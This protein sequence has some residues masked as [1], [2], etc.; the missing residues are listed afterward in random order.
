MSDL[1]P[2]PFPHLLVRMMRELDERESIFDLPRSKFFRGSEGDGGGGHDLSV[3]LHGQAAATPLGPSAGPHSQMAQN[4]VL[5]YL[6]GSR[7]MELKTVQVLDQLEIGRPCID[8]AT[9]CYNIEWSQEL[10]IAE[11][12]EE[13]VKA[14]MLID[15]LVASGRLDL[16]PG[17][18]PV[19]YDM[20]VGYD[21]AGIQSQPVRAFIEGMKDATAIVERLRTQIPAEFAQFR[22]LDF[23]TKLSNSLTLS[24]FHGCPPDEI[25][26][27]IDFL[28]R[29]LGLDC[30]IKL[31][32]TLLGPRR[33]KELLID[34]LGY[35]EAVTPDEAFEKD[36][37]WEQMLGFV[38]RLG[39]TAT[40]L[41]LGLGVKFT[42]TLIV[43]NHRDFFPSSEKQM[44]LSGQPLHVL[45][46]NLV[47]D[48]RR[49][50][51]D[52]VPVSFSAGI[53]RANFPDAVASGLVP[54][55]VCS[56]LLRPGGYGRQKSYFQSL[57]KRMD[58]V[59]ANDIE[60]FILRAYGATRV[61]LE[62]AGGDWNP[63]IES[64]IENGQD[65]RPIV[66]E[67][68]LGRWLGAAK[69]INT[70]L[71]T[72]QATADERYRRQQTNR[73]PK[74]IGSMLELFNCI[75]CDK[76]I[77]V[78]P[79]DANF[80]LAIDEVEVPLIKVFKRGGEWVSEANGTLVLD[81]K[82]QI[83]NFD[84]FCNDCGNCDV[85]CP[86]DGGPY[87]LKPRFFGSLDAWSE[88]D[89][90]DGFFVKRSDKTEIVHGRFAGIEYRLDVEGGRARYLGDGF[91]VVF[92]MADPAGTIEGEADS[93][94]DL[95]Y[96][97]IMNEICK[98]IFGKGKPVNFMNV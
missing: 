44:Y 20:S 15:I 19:I 38:D 51:G 25:E 52:S 14:S 9:V 10:R 62:K 93:V 41:G 89:S 7:I 54:V 53:D 49:E 76:C 83:G 12:L 43:E 91:E 68:L 37:K 17:L 84:D 28:L 67:E 31:N 88:A 50:F 86:E 26:R 55:T 74:K 77:P 85:F 63:T 45:A 27:I 98:A 13:Y 16:T 24:T 79:N 18:E 32:P 82:H 23:R 33:M 2:Q 81:K 64:A 92:S 71:Y 96:F 47:R 66:G 4:I 60:G 61:A 97:A 36:T 65:L 87:V 46:M 34:T 58:R 21:L 90:L 75:T 3:R 80:V 48:F 35:T 94:V 1:I 56:D 22:N 95:A 40:E 59:G 72:E 8:A 69:V 30:I 11:S 29:E 5:S 70:E 57:I 6:G 73:P 78:C 42:N 39:K